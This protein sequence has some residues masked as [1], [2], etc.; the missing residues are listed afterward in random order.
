MREGR[1][2]RQIATVGIGLALSLVAGC[3][4]SN[5]KTKVYRDAFAK[6]QMD[7]ACAEVDKRIWNESILEK[8][9]DAVVEKDMKDWGRDSV[10]YLLEQ[11]TVLR[12]ANRLKESN[13]A[14]ERADKKMK[15]A[16]EQPPIKVSAEIQA[17]TDNLGALPYYGYA[18]DHVMARTYMG[19]NYIQLGDMPQARNMLYGSEMVQREYIEKRS[20]KIQDRKE[21][22]AKENKAGKGAPKPETLKTDKGQPA[23]AGVDALVSRYS[24]YQNYRNPFT[25]W[26]YGITMMATNQQSQ[27][28]S[29]AKA[30]IEVAA[31]MAPQNTSVQGDLQLVTE[32]IAGKEI[33][34]TTYVVY[35]SG[36]GPIRGD[37]ILRLPV[38]TGAITQ[39]NIAYVKVALPTLQVRD[40]VLPPLDIAAGGQSYRTE[41]LAS[42]DGIVAREFKDELPLVVTKSLISSVFKAVTGEV[43]RKQAADQDAMAGLIVLIANIVYQETTTRADLR[44]WATLPKEFQVCRIPTPE[45][46]TITINTIG[47]PKAIKLEP[48]KINMVYVKAVQ[49]LAPAIVWQAKL[50]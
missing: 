7:I 45:D 41:P 3:Q 25:T 24:A 49:P 33:P 9:K 36:L 40:S 8:K 6:G 46:R 23:Y 11:G 27:D 50:N 37:F 44:Q 34:P 13:V 18:Y 14:F 47:G 48:G 35:E 26:L 5:D 10:M 39:G 20:K 21:E 29:T 2:W 4:N 17:L 30:A 31:G 12:A 16:W 19:L 15:A 1:S 28:L 22:F 43:V 42:V 38:P 32:A